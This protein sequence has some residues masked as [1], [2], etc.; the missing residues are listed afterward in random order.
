MAGGPACVTNR[1]LPA[2]QALSRAM[3]T[4]WGKTPVFRRDGGS[5]P[6]VA[7]M[8]E[9]LGVDS[10]L[11]GFSMPDDHIHA[12]NERLHLPTWQKGIQALICFLFN[13]AD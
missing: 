6:V 2:V 7:H 11:T 12:P 3:E 1:D 8:Q 9:I 5:V 10:I 4:V 13:L